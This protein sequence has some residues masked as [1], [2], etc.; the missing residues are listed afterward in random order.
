MYRYIYNS[1]NSKFIIEI[2]VLVT[3]VFIVYKFLE[4]LKSHMLYFRILW[5]IPFC[6]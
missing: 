6:I 2:S 3:F 4:Y 1:V 5:I